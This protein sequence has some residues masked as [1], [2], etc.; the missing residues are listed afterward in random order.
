[1]DLKRKERKNEGGPGRLTWRMRMREE[2]RK[3]EKEE[4]E[5]REGRVVRVDIYRV[6]WGAEK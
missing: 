6:P 5:V 1:M 4:E 2:G 3:G